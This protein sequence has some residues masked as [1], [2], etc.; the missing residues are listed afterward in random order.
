MRHRPDIAPQAIEGWGRPH[1]MRRAHY[2]RGNVSLCGLWRIVGL[3]PLERRKPIG[4]C[5][6]CAKAKTKPEGT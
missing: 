1:V 2:F 4:A 5:S 3:E 6:R